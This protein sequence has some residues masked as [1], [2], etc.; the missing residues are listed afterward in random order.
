MK[1]ISLCS[2]FKVEAC[3]SS[4]E[5][6]KIKIR[7]PLLVTLTISPF[8]TLTILETTLKTKSKEKNVVLGMNVRIQNLGIH[9]FFKSNPIG[10]TTSRHATPL[11][12]PRGV[13]KLFSHSRLSKC[14]W[15]TCLEG[16]RSRAL[17]A[18]FSSFKSFDS[19]SGFLS[20]AYCTKV[21][22]EGQKHLQV[23]TEFN[24]L[25][26]EQSD[27]PYLQDLLDFISSDDTVIDDSDVLP[28]E[29]DLMDQLWS[30]LNSDN[31]NNSDDNN[32]QSLSAPCE[33]NVINNT[34]INETES[35]Q[36][37]LD[38]KEE[39]KVVIPL[40]NIVQISP[41]QFMVNNQITQE[42]GN[43]ST[44]ISQNN[45]VPFT[46]TISSAQN[47]TESST[48]T[49]SLREYVLTNNYFEHR[50]RNNEACKKCRQKK[51]EKEAEQK[52]ELKLLEERNRELKMKVKV[53]TE[54]V[55]DIRSET[56]TN[57]S[58]SAQKRKSDE[59]PDFGNKRDRQC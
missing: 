40:Y 4:I 18:S 36:V 26:M 8:Q 34:P 31:G 16:F 14:P 49:N 53:M 1:I 24:C 6:N 55:E 15:P 46:S 32:L 33:I 11:G 3:L 25:K 59:S 30:S 17:K 51:K 29:Q 37:L 58:N 7:F 38:K 57:I 52:K 20:L 28:N 56:L 39:E 9:I 54:I 5:K 41:N 19:T 13:P 45:S 22:Q 43:V 47:S 12:D 48:S 44:V 27:N 23:F 2:S 21:A 42:A 10:R 50:R 35:S